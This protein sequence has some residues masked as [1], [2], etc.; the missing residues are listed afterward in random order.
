MRF[1]EAMKY[2]REGKPIVIKDTDYFLQVNIKNG[3]IF[4][5]RQSFSLDIYD[6][7][8]DEWE[9]MDEI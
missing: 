3:E 9:V 4:D 5:C 1:E 2:L 8:G 6:I 7:L